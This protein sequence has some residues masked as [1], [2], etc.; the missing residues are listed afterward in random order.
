[1]TL[2]D[3]KINGDMIPCPSSWDRA[4]LMTSYE[5]HYATPKELKQNGGVCRRC[6]L[7][8]QSRNQTLDGTEK[9]VEILSNDRPL[10]PVLDCIGFTAACQPEQVVPFDF[11]KIDEALGEVESTSED[12]QAQAAALFS[13]IMSWV[14]AGPNVSLHHATV[15][16]AV[17]TGGLRPELIANLSYREIGIRMGITKQAVTKVA[18]KFEDAFNFRFSRSRPESAR[19]HMRESATGHPPTNTKHHLPQ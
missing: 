6:F 2:P 13:Q 7:T 19:V 11:G 10:D 8:F 4:N 3:G 15:R 12:T 5:V 18:K 9:P 16:F 17:L 1:M 14:W